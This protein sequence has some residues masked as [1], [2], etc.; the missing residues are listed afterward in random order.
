MPS[1]TIDGISSGIDTTSFINAI[2]QFE[3]QPAVLMENEQAEKTNIVSA[4]KALQAKVLALSTEASRLSYAKAFESASVVV[5]DESVLTASSSGRVS[6]GSYDLR[7][8]ALARNHQLASQGISDQSLSSFGTG[9]ISLKVGNNS[10][11]AITIDSGNNSL[12]GIKNA[13]NNAKIGVTASIVND[14]SLSNPYRL[15]LSA[16]KTGAANKIT[17]SSNLNGS[18][19]LNFDT[20]SFDIPELVN[21]NSGSDTKISLGS[22]AAYS[23]TEN[24]IYT[25]TVAGTGSQIV[26]TDNITINWT[27]GTNSGS[28][29]VTQA[30]SEVELVGTGADGLKLSFSVGEINAGDTFQVAG[31]APLLQEAADAKL[32]IGSSGGTGSPITITSEN[33]T[34]KDVIS[35][36]TLNIKKENAVGETVNITTDVDVTGIKNTIETFIQRYNDVINYIDTQNTY[37]IETGESGVLFADYTVQI[38]QNSLRRTLT[39]KIDGIDSQ[40]NQL[41]AIGI[42]TGSD[43]KLSIKDSSRLEEALRNNLDDV[44]KLFTN[45]GKSTNA[46]ISFVSSTAETKVGEYE[47]NI[48]RAATRGR[49]QGGGIAD[50]AFTPITLT[51]ANNRLRFSIDGLESEDIVL[52]EKTYNSSE[53]LVSELQAK[54]NSDRRIGNRG[55]TVEWVSTGNTGYLN[56]QSSTYG[57]GSKVNIK[58]SV[59]SSAFAVL[60]LLSG[61]SHDGLDVQGTINGEAAEGKGQILTG[62]TGNPNTDGLKI[63]VTLDA[64]QLLDGAEGTITLS[65]GAAARLDNLLDSINRSGDGLLSRR[66]KS[67]ENQVNNLKE[68]IDDFDKRL[69]LRRE[70]LVVKF[71]KMEEIL[72]ELSATSEYLTSQLNNIQV[73][74]K[75]NNKK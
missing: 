65:N 45:S 51:S 34:F 46:A 24:K 67:Y 50:P 22:T 1:F 31:F 6:T 42:R 60:G 61:A 53:E 32:T 28:I 26:G 38:M 33:N 48:T 30:D 54:I 58:T 2:I 16:D 25:F 43:G 36:L 15:I 73:N 20:T 29:L 3:R 4:L 62:K 63:K 52:T 57:S 70:S 9:T 55:L 72:S 59:S 13:I 44:I 19:G 14:G 12:V 56:L 8:V 66:I 7:V 11:T 35:G 18:L 64:S 39:S 40:Y 5:S 37:N 41:Y 49:F 75:F 27:D 69:T 17:V 21:M 74:W 10:L 23:G 47:V 68:R 71:N